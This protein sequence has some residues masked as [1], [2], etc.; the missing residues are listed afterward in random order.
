[1]VILIND[2]D[3]NFQKCNR[4]KTEINYL[5]KIHEPYTNIN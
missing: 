3:G 2:N 4:R 5:E 1:M